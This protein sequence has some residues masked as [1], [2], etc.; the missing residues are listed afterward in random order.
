M[1]ALLDLIFRRYRCKRCGM[2]YHTELFAQHCER[3]HNPYWWMHRA[4]DNPGDM[5]ETCAMHGRRR[6]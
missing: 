3:T 4:V 6:T 5:W 1:T 2:R